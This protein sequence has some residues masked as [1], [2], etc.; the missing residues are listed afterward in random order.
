MRDKLRF[1]F[2]C[3]SKPYRLSYTEWSI[4]WW[5]W[6]LAIPKAHNPALDDC[7]NNCNQNQ[8]DKNVWFL[9]GT[10]TPLVSAKRT[11]V[12][13]FGRAILFPIVNNLVSYTEYP[14]LKK[15]DD[16]K[17]VA[18]KDFTK[19]LK[20]QVGIGNMLITSEACRIGS[21]PFEISYPD[22]NIFNA[23]PGLSIAVS[24]GFWIFLSP[25]PKGTFSVYFVAVEPN[26]KTEVHY[27]L[28]IV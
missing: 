6:L 12:L 16:L 15:D 23:R 22:G 17:S 9:A 1:A 20:M 19:E 13:P 11:C 25:L 5:R 3:D 28:R 10:V 27:T 4:L 7:G 26:Y 8:F 18:G 2:R 21:E 24:D 14:G